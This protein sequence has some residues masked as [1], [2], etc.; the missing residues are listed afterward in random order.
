MIGR[1]DLCRLV[2]SAR[3][4]GSRRR[5]AH[6]ALDALSRLLCFPCHGR[7]IWRYFYSVKILLD[8][9]QRSRYAYLYNVKISLREHAMQQE[10][11]MRAE[12]TNRGPIPMECD[13]PFLKITGELPCELNG[14]LYR[15]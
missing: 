15:N 13:A 11:P 2:P 10:T 8:P 3:A 6:G 14:T 9:S 5:A 1:I 7:V 12:W 4:G